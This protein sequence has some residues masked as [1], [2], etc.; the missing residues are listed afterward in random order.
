MPWPYQRSF[1]PRD[2]PGADGITQLTGDVAAGP[3]PGS[4]VATIQPSVVTMAKMAN[5]ATNTVIGRSTAGTGSPEALTSITPASAAFS[6]TAGAG[7]VSLLTQ[8]SVP[9]APATGFALY[10]D[11]SGKFSWRRADGNTRTF[12]V[13]ASTGNR[14]FTLP[15]ASFT[16]AGQN[17]ANTFSLAQVFSANGALSAPAVSF[18][19]TPIMGGT[20]TTT[21]PMVLIETAGAASSAWQITGTVFGVNA[22]SGFTGSLVDFQLNGGGSLFRISSTGQINCSS[23]SASPTAVFQ[24]ASRGILSSPTAGQVQ[25]G[26][27]D[28]AAPVAQKLSTQS[29]V[30]GTSN[31]AGVSFTRVV[32]LGTGTG[33]SG[34]DILQQGITGA[35]GTTQNTAGT[36]MYR[37]AKETTLTE[38]T[39]T[40]LFTVTV[41]TGKYLAAVVEC[42]VFASD[43]TDF[44]VLHSRVVINTANK[45]GTIGTTGLTQT[46]ATGYNTSGTLTPVTYTLVDNGSGVA[47]LKCAATSSLSQTTLSCKWAISII[48]SND[49][50]TVTPN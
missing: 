35:S 19:G 31:T 7:F 44:Q 39:A 10:A 20:A 15:D 29:V 22:P 38:A 33:G 3:G 13:A 49:A 34:D 16:F 2:N 43:G 48:N 26:A 14:T 11:S 1:W 4:V 46:D 30:A 8:S 27:A 9:A 41:P 42:T 6:G 5:I 28:A 24:W 17:L 37:R 12:E 32:S 23:I 25:L 47:A 21:K 45:A 50:A 36:R 18:T 40:T